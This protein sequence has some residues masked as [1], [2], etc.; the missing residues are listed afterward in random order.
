[1][2]NEQGRAQ[3]KGLTGF[4]P[5]KRCCVW[6]GCLSLKCLLIC[7]QTNDLI[8]GHRG[9]KPRMNILNSVDASTK[10]PV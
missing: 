1:M 9:L 4:F 10:A 5:I 8:V 7:V 3:R 2:A 6:T